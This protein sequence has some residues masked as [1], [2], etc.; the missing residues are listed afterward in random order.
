[1]N[2]GTNHHLNWAIYY[3]HKT[4]ASFT[5]SCGSSS[6]DV[7]S[8]LFLPG[9]LVLLR[10][11]CRR[12]SP[13]TPGPHDPSPKPSIGLIAWPPPLPPPLTLVVAVP[14]APAVMIG[15]TE[16][17]AGLAVTVRLEGGREL[18]SSSALSFICSRY[19]R[20]LQ[21]HIFE[22]L[23]RKYFKKNSLLYPGHTCIWTIDL[24]AEFQKM[25]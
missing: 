11:R 1:M 17:S 20:F 3:W 2:E 16:M 22:C 18:P 13:P 5:C 15:L 4:F 14:V 21:E 23:N 25:G 7:L 12:F 19:I 8:D 10:S 24:C 6:D 9:V